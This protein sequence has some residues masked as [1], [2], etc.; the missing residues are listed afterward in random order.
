MLERILVYVGTYTCPILFGGGKIFEGKGKG[1]YLLELDLHTGDLNFLETF[2]NI[3]NPSYLAI[4]NKNSFLYAV[5]ELKEFQGKPSGS[6]SSFKIS[7]TSGKLTYVNKQP[8]NGTDPCHV[9]VNLEGT[10]LFVS[11]FMTSLYFF[12]SH[13]P[14]NLFVPFTTVNNPFS[15]KNNSLFF[16]CSI[17]FCFINL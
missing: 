9:A 12:L 11:N 5:N 1:I 7:E 2:T 10:K 4:N 15:C 16:F 3:V 13:S 8:T 17:V 14:T 6:V